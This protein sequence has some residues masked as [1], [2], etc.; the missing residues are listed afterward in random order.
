MVKELVYKKIGIGHVN[1]DSSMCPRFQR[2]FL[3]FT[4]YLFI[5]S[6]CELI[7]EKND[8]LPFYIIIY[9]FGEVILFVRVQTP[10]DNSLR[11][12]WHILVNREESYRVIT[13]WLLWFW[14]DKA[15]IVG[16]PKNIR[17]EYRFILKWNFEIRRLETFQL[18]IK[19][20]C[21]NINL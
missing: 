5:F 9:F 12:I 1:D 19:R 2:E 17:M 21:W 20:L 8:S 3:I 4:L 14:R 10:V 15:Q 6:I 16:F 11:F 13:L 18:W 7:L